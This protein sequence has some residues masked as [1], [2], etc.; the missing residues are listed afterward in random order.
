MENNEYNTNR[1][2]KF[3]AIKNMTYLQ[4]YEEY[5]RSK[6][7]EKEITNL[8]EIESEFYTT[9]YIYFAMTLMDFFGAKKN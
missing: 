9:R 6:E 1:K 5:L 4:I 3:V 8:K 2:F 7:F